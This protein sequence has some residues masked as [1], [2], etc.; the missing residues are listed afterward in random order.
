MALVTDTRFLLQEIHAGIT[1]IGFQ[2][3]KVF[4]HSVDAQSSA[5]GGI[6]IQV[7][8]EMSNKGESWKK[9]VQTFFLA[10]QPNGYFVL[11]DIFRFL[12]EETVEDEPSEESEPP[13]QDALVVSEQP[14]APA[15]TAPVLELLPSEADPEPVSEPVRTPTPP[16]VPAPEPEELEVPVVSEPV[17]EQPN[18]SA[19]KELEF[20]PSEPTVP[21]APETPAAHS[22]LPATSPAPPAEPTAPSPAPPPIVTPVAS[23]PA[24]AAPVPTAPPVRKTWANLAATG[25]NKWGSNV[26][27][28]V[29]GVSEAPVTSSSP[30]PSAPHTP[31]PRGQ[32]QQPHQAYVQ[33]ASIPHAQCFVK[34]CYPLYFVSRFVLV[35]MITRAS[36]KP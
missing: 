29:K 17:A 8:G 18:G 10:E 22:P 15:T 9:F 23:A 3:C 25:S 31:A 7:I 19:P 6:I 11:N 13:V 5:N 21:S 2:D 34:V 35:T 26:A 20:M 33:A 32:G 16:P 12:K 30:A 14:P 28:E 36:P 24:P 1:S 4:I 27:Q